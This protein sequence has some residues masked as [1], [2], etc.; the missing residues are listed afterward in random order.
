[1]RQVVALELFVPQRQVLVV[2]EVMSHVVKDV[3]EDASREDGSG[4][5]PIPVE[6]S[7]CELPERRG[8]DDKQSRRHDEAIFVHRQVVVNAMKEEMSS[9]ANT[10]VRD[11]AV[12]TIST[13]IRKV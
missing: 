2:E 5:E 8:Q 6:D 1:M 10:V 7:V 9:D 11:I 3:A 13:M 12:A 4:H